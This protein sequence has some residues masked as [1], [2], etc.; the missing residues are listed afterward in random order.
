[1]FSYL[2]LSIFRSIYIKMIFYLFH[3]NQYSPTYT[4][5]KLFNMQKKV[6][7]AM[8]I[9]MFI[10]FIIKA[11]WVPLKNNNTKQATPN[12][13]LVSDDNN[14]SVF[15]IDISGFDLKNINTNGIEYQVVDLLSES[16][17]SKP[18]M[19]ALPY[20][21]KTFAIPEQ[22][23]V[24]VEI[25]GMS[26]IQTFHNINLAPARES[27][28][29]GN[30]ETPYM[31]NASIYNAN[32]IFP[33]NLVNIDPPAIFR[34]FRIARVSV[35]PFRYNPASKELQVATSLT[36][37]INYGS[38]KTENPKTTSKKPI[39]PSFGQLYKDFIFNYE[40]VLDKSYDGKE[41]GHELMLCIMPDEFYD[42]FQ[43]YAEWKRQ[44]GIDIHITKFSDIG[45][46]SSNVDIIKNHI[47]DAYHN[48]EVPPTY[49]LLVGD[50]GVFPKQMITLD[51]W[52]FP[53]EDYFVETDG[54]DFFP[55]MMIGR[56]TNQSDYS[57]QVM[58]NKFQKYEQTPYIA[59]TDWF[60]KGICCSNNYYES[61]IETKR[62]AAERM[63]QD[64]GFTSVDTMMSDPGCTYSI[65]DVMNAID[66][67]RS[68]LNYRGE[69][70]S[71]GWNATCASLHTSNVSNLNNGEKL[72]FVT[73]IGCGVA[74]FNTSGGNC[75]GEEWLELGTIS[76]PKGAVAFV[77]PSSNTHT[78][79]NNKLDKGIYVGMFQEMLSTPGQG[80][81]RGKLYLYN[82]Y[83]TDPYVEYHYKIYCVLGDPSI[84]IWKEIPKDVTV[85]Y[86]ESITFG[87]NLVEF[88]VN[89]T[90]TGLPVEGAVVCI[91]GNEIFV[92]GITDA[93]GKVYL[94][95]ISEDLETLN[96]TVTGHTVY[97]F[98]G[99][100]EVLPP[101]GPWVVKDYY[102]L[103]DNVGGNG[104]N[105]MDYGESILLSLAVKNIGPN[106][107][108]NINV[109]LSTSDP[110]ITITD[111]LHNYPSVLSG[112]SVLATNAFSF[113]VADNMPNGHEVI[114]NVTASGL[115]NSW[116]SYMTI[117]GQAPVIS[118]GNI[119]ISDPGG[120]NNG[121]LDPGETVT[122]TF[123]VSNIGN[124]NS[125]DATA[126][127]SSSYP[128]F[129]LN[130]T[131]DNLGLINY[132]ETT[133]ASFN[134]TVS[135]DANMGDM[136][137]LEAEVIAGAYDTTKS[138]AA[139][140]GYMIEDWETGGFDKFPWTMGG[141]AD[142]TL[143]TEN[144]QQG[145]YSARSG[146]IPD[147]QTSD[148]EI[149]INVTGDGNITFFKKVSSEN[150]YDY[151]RFYIDGSMI[152]QWSGNV[153]WSQQSY[154]V[155][156]GLH[157]FVW[158][159]YKDYTVSGGDDCAWIDYI[160]FPSPEPPEL[161]ITPPY[162]TAF[163]ESG[164]I[165]VGWDNDS[166]D[167]FDWT[168]ISGP[169]P[170]GVT[171][172]QGDHT[173]GNGYY[174]YTESSNPNYPDKRADL[175]SPT[176]D[177][178]DL[179]DVVV[180]FW[181]HMF[182]NSTGSPIM[183]DLH[184]DVFHNNVWI[185][186]VMTPISGNQGD[187]WHE[188]EVDLSAFDGEIITFRF[189]GVTGGYASDICIDDF[190]IDGIEYPLG[191]TLDLT[192]FLEGPC[193]GTEMTTNLCACSVLPTSQPFNT[194]PWNYNG[195]ESANTIPGNVVDWVLVELRDATSAE[196][197]TPATMI[198]RQ[199]G[200]LLNDGSIVATDG[201][202]LLYF[203]NTIANNLYTVIYQ[204]N[205]LTIMSANNLSLADETAT[206]DF[207]TSSDQAYGNNS[208]KL[209]SPNLWGMMSGDCN[210]DGAVGMDDIVPDFDLNAGKTG[211]F[212]G[213]LNL[214]SQVN[215]IDK[216]EYWFP[217][218]GEGTNVP[219]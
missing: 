42:S 105:L 150:N 32:D 124:S 43:S 178:I 217:N 79:Y 101:T 61:Q 159:Y 184:L 102:L 115:F 94:E 14:S 152:D 9:V 190:S 118:L 203:D 145:T 199:A 167:D 30:P 219:Q 149:T 120:N 103:D 20:I 213:D 75:F 55:E 35:Y 162:Q 182:N 89:H 169:T 106:N 183:G 170:T 52:S 175:I 46:N 125:P 171:G 90:A 65:S 155:S 211:W 84:H 164:I 161:P 126:Y 80:L 193:N 206:Y 197:A 99:T 177:L 127:L 154:A 205:H 142:W 11:E 49:V 122:I 140:I 69:G 146:Y 58:I 139:S 73:S 19:P 157:T 147:S 6:S 201:S 110:Y 202:S 185:E 44:S 60:K 180:K 158:Q 172:P 166:D 59:N 136:V 188:H 85:D 207:T 5:I 192:V 194:V 17:I 218:N 141:N 7:F 153:A 97:P 117:T 156:A 38:G 95:I 1:M 71:S 104:N 26:E 181:Y 119:I 63:L 31:E 130:N 186:D 160:V 189:R 41:T 137:D 198:D 93:T 13:T 27:W 3:T 129:T 112:Q 200:L 51:G 111:N 37:R 86:P 66:N 12:V 67:G 28:Q 144:P 187:Q 21:A 134:A 54:N 92:S 15:K 78:T 107:A 50:D 72:T 29:E 45:A 135:M 83:G 174:M 36:V 123:P 114:I 116:N 133:N 163:E 195:L 151:L 143:V 76:S 77:G 191:V 108:T 165:P 62:F 173:N 113:T 176:F 98:Q 168:V 24:S 88:T 138:Y 87:T 81:L 68:Y 212:P 22:A 48:W 196:N 216:D 91:T 132:G 210:A 64:G 209:L 82:V 18:G 179:G 39:A 128:F 16:F 121:L 4:F 34:D 40:S 109:E 23:A 74:M 10:P 2:W 208:Q 96:V 47:S 215:N 70:W 56:L 33:S 53:N 204:R 57:M 131:T 148:L 25:L 8:L 100:L 214:D